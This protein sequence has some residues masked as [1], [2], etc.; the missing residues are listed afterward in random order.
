MVNEEQKREKVLELI[1][2][3]DTYKN[4]F[5]RK[6]GH[7]KWFYALKKEGYFSADNVPGPEKSDSGGYFLP[8]SLP[9]KYI[10][11][12]SEQIA[13]GNHLH[14]V[15]EIIE[16]VRDVSEKKVDNPHVWHDIIDIISNLPNNKIPSDI[17]DYVEVWLKSEFRNSLPSSELCEKLLPKFLIERPTKNDREKAEKILLKALTLVEK[18]ESEKKNTSVGL[19]KT[20]KILVDL[21]WLQNV[22]VKENLVERIGKGLSN[23]V[24]FQLA[25]N[26]KMLL[27]DFPNGL[28]LSEENF[29]LRVFVENR[30]LRVKLKVEEEQEE[31]IIEHFEN[32]APS[33]LSKEIKLSF[34]KVDTQSLDYED[35]K[36]KIDA[37]AKRV[38]ID[39]STIW[40]NSIH[41]LG[42]DYLSRDELKMI[43]TLILRDLLSIKAKHREKEFEEIKEAF[44]SNKFKLPLFKRFLLYAISKNWS[45]QSS[46]FWQMI[47][48]EGAQQFFSD[49]F[50]DKEI[51]YLLRANIKNFKKREREKLTH[52]IENGPID[53]GKDDYEN[54]K[55]YWQLQWYSALKDD[56]EYSENYEKLSKELNLTNVH[57]EELGEVKTIVGDR[58]PYEV[59]E[60]L[61]MEASQLIE[62]FKTY[63]PENSFDSPSI[64]GFSRT[65]SAAVKKEP[66]YF[67]KQLHLYKNIPYIYADHLI[68]GFEEAWKEKK[69]FDWK[70]VLTFCLTYIQSGEFG[71][72]SLKIIEDR[73]GADKDWAIGSIGNLIST[74]TRDDDHAFSK[75]YLPITWDILSVVIPTLEIDNAQN[76]ITGDY[77]TYVLNSTAGK[78]LRALVDYSLRCARLAENSDLQK[79]R[80]EEKEL[81]EKT[82]QKGIID[83]YILLGWNFR[84]FNYLDTNWIQNKVKEY[85]TLPNEKWKAFIGGFVFNNPI[86]D[87][88]IYEL[89]KPHFQRIIKEGQYFDHYGESTVVRHI[90]MFYIWDFE[91][92]NEGDLITDFLSRS[93][94]DQIMK[95][96]NFFWRIRRHITGEKEGEVSDKVY[97]FWKQVLKRFSASDNDQDEEVLSN[98]TKLIVYVKELKKDNIDLVKKLAPYANL[99]FN[100]PILLEELNRLKDEGKPKQTAKFLGE[101]LIIMIK[102]Y[103]PDGMEKEVKAIVEFLYENKEKD[104]SIVKMADEICVTYTKKER[105]FLRQV[106]AKNKAET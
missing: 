78:L 47:E 24:P 30:N 3:D 52:I 103:I 88:E 54:Y 19:E 23:K 82:L 2:I 49:S 64:I 21:Y 34:D 39:Y 74:G 73:W 81:F 66:Q 106:Y 69:D 25:E 51:Y 7:I 28:T 90:G 105:Y 17:F 94:S 93:E 10:K 56:D 29:S 31:I 83:G 100:A 77:P 43:Q 18:S 5:F 4:Y 1:K 6:V 91:S 16:I 71:N 42:E 104:D 72:D 12:L 70:N 85:Y 11:R 102:N 89:F 101:L 40:C 13:E 22:L 14:I 48:R 67:D 63:K 35:Y 53:D 46:A 80:D 61:D 59:S 99:N 76:E 65:L 75:D 27:L 37:I 58:S 62:Q 15:D 68:R 87:K 95:L 55:K 26:L 44:L 9:L 57:Y 79:W 92:L 41:K 32:Y 84:Q 45:Q 38:N 98:L 33:D 36:E 20:Y 60:I 86:S 97:D 8:S 50:F 96:I